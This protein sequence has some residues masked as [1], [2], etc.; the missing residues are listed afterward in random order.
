MITF[1]FRYTF[2][3][4]CAFQTSPNS[5]MGINPL[6]IVLSSCLNWISNSMKTQT[7]EAALLQY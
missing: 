4:K 3:K 7:V 1:Y 2:R 5:L 6:P